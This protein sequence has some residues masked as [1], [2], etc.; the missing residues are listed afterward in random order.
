[1]GQYQVAIETGIDLHLDFMG[2]RDVGRSERNA[3]QGTA[4]TID[5]TVHRIFIPK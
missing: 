5:A 3:D 2:G 4:T 1:L